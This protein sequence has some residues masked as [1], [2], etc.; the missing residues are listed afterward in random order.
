MLAENLARLLLGSPKIS[1]A[2]FQTMV[3]HADATLSKDT[4]FRA[5]KDVF[6][7]D[8]SVDFYY[9]NVGEMDS[10]LER[11]NLKS[12]LRILKVYASTQQEPEY[13]QGMS[14]IASPILYVMQNEPLAYQVFAAVMARQVSPFLRHPFSLFPLTGPVL[15]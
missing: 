15:H 2:A 4:M 9:P 3:E 6:R 8:R 13:V 14:D 11:P 10:D 7:S 5:Q 12:L 1:N